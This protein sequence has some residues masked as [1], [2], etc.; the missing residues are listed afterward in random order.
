MKFRL[1]DLLA[2]PI[3]KS[4]PLKLIVF[5]VYDITPPRKIVKCELYCSYHSR[6]IKDL[7]KTECNVCYSREI[8]SGLLICSSC[9]RWYPIEDDIPR[10]LPDEL[11]QK[12]EDIA[13]MYKWK[14]RISNEIL[15]DGKPFNLTQDIS[16]EREKA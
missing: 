7:E 15:N 4:F 14:D 3:C 12:N 1:V 8:K 2:C 13:F 11:R 10:M 5:E 16:T 6:F 9:K